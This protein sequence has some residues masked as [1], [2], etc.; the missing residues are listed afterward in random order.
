MSAHVGD[1]LL[2]GRGR[3]LCRQLKHC[4]RLTLAQER[5]Q[6][7][8]PIWKFERIVM[9]GRLVLVDLS[10]D[11][12]PVA[13]VL[14][15]LPQQASRQ[16]RNFPG[17]GQFRSGITHTASSRSSAAEK[18]RV[19]VPKSRVTS[20]SLTFAGRERTLWR[21][22]SH[23]SRIPIGSPFSPSHISAL[24]VLPHHTKLRGGRFLSS[25][26]SIR[27]VLFGLK[28]LTRKL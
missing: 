25:R 27:P 16:A 9:R 13:D 19:P 22:K 2:L 14:R 24:A 6:H 3:W 26:T 7:G 8:P 4:C 1:A 23:I 17:E 20:L 21:L 15:L 10:K 11:C 18:P 12:R 5:Q 28:D